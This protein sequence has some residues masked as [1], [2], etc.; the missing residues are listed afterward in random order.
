MSKISEWT[1]APQVDLGAFVPFVANGA[2][3]KV[4]YSN[5]LA[6]VTKTTVGLGNVDNTADL[7]KPISTATQAALNAKAAVSHIHAISD[8]TNLQTELNSKAA[9]T[10]THTASNISDFNT[11]V[12]TVIDA[13]IPVKTIV[14]SPVDEW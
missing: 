7:A 2:N 10:H 9:T 14:T 11:A 1:L 6:G 13:Q 3:Y 8:V 4:T 5:F 12:S